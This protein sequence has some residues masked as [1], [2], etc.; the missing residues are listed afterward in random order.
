MESFSIRKADQVFVLNEMTSKNIVTHL[1]ILPAKVKLIPNGVNTKVYKKIPSD[2]VDL[3]QLRDKLNLNGRKV[4]FHAGAVCDRKNQLEII[5]YLTPAF[6]QNPEIV[7]LYAGGIREKEYYHSISDYCSGLNIANNVVYLGEIPPGKILNYY[8]NL[9]I[10]FVFFSKAEGFSLA[11]LEALSSGL[12][13]LLSNN[14]EIEFIADK[15][16]GILL[17]ENQQDFQSTF[18]R[19]IYSDER[20]KLH[21]ENASQFIHRNYSW[22]TITRMYFG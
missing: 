7:F 12:P 2:D 4:L 10:G 5:K 14:L 8:Y 3:I 16:N 9:A 15:H 11:L 18:F 6:Q 20:Q 1:N 21:S 19:E 22:D 17:F 13:V